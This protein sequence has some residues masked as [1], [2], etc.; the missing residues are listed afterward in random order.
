MSS[1]RCKGDNSA[2][3]IDSLCLAGLCFVI[4]DPINRIARPIF[5]H[6]AL[7]IPTSQRGDGPVWI[8]PDWPVRRKR[9]C[10]GFRLLLRRIRTA[11]ARRQKHRQQEPAQAN[12]HD[13]KPHNIVLNMLLVRLEKI[14]MK[15]SLFRAGVNVFS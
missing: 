12:N 15:S 5:E 3:Q 7:R 1:R 8:G 9:R 2:I 4:V 6:G 13:E 10:R 11:A 14:T